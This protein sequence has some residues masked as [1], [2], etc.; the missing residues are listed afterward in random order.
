MYWV[1]G[2]PVGVI[3]SKI[4]LRLGATRKSRRQLRVAPAISDRRLFVDFV[5]LVDQL[6]DVLGAGIGSPR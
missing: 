4:G 1:R 5:A 3:E 2:G 6:R